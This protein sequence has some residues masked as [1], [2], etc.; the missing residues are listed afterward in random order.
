M[1]VH[2]VLW[3]LVSLISC[4]QI[5]FTSSNPFDSESWS[6][7]VHFTFE[8]YDTSPFWDDAGNSYIVGSHAY[9]VF[10]MLQAFSMDFATGNITSEI[11]D[12]WAGTGGLVRSSLLPAYVMEFLLATCCRLR[13]DHISTKRMVISTSRLRKGERVRLSATDCPSLLISKIPS[14][15]LNHETDYARSDSLFGNY[16]SDPANP[17]LTNANTTE[18]CASILKPPKTYSLN[19][20]SQSKLW[21]T[22]TYS[23]IPKEIGAWSSLRRITFHSKVFL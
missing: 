16:T 14:S 10:P 21:G 18:Y 17:V 5:I 3:L 8:G 12:L 7:P 13:R 20:T 1:Y 23:T 6:D 4:L 11:H 2:L 19:Y 22:R 15:G 9:H